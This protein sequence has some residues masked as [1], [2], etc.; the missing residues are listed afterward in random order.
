MASYKPSEMTKEVC[1]AINFIGFFENLYFSI[2]LYPNDFLKLFFF[3]QI[4]IQKIL[5]KF[6]FYTFL[7]ETNVS[8]VYFLLLQL[9]L[10]R[11]FFCLTLEN[12][13]F[14]KYNKIGLGNLNLK[15]QGILFSLFIALSWQ[16]VFLAEDWEFFH[17]NLFKSQYKKLPFKLLVFLF[18]ALILINCGNLLLIFQ[19]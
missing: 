16:L 1:L 4:L 9:T 18:E 13:I 8:S 6:S 10:L 14:F 19:Y 15:I 12:M 11:H 2:N 7:F 17:R 5:S 3:W